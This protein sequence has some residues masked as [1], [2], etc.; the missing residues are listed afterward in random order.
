ML[1]T[2]YK[3]EMDWQD[4]LK[5]PRKLFGYSYLYFLAVVVVLGLLYVWNL[6]T[7]GRNSVPPFVLKDSSALIQDIPLQS[8][9]VIP[10]V[11]V[12]KVGVSSPE[13]ISKGGELYKNSC[14]ACHGDAGSGDGPSAAMLNPKPRNF[15]SLAAWKNGS[16]ITQ[17]YKTLQEGIPGS[18]M[19][20]YNYM[21]PEDRFALIHYVRTFADNQP[22]DSI[23]DLKQI[24]AVYGLSKGMNVTGQIPIK[25]AIALI[26]KES[27]LQIVEI[28][29]ALKSF[30]SSNSEGAIIL[31]RVTRDE[32]RMVISLLQNKKNILNLDEFIK[33]ITAD[34]LRIGFGANVAHL[35]ADEWSKMHKY[36]IALAGKENQK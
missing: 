29:E 3:P 20:S 9:R 19:A 6:N 26:A 11:D 33:V 13:F 23:E 28:A 5:Q 10:P 35:S 1:H 36:I 4:L 22:K 17:I 15:H 12:M 34:P 2:E 25:K 31:R 24:D 8:P 32:T 7:I 16:K 27:K 21:P 14:A 18:S 30:R